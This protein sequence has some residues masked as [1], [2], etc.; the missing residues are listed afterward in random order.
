MATGYAGSA[1]GVNRAA[2]KRDH[3][4]VMGKGRGIEPLALSA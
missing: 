2:T 1:T 4:I 3:Q